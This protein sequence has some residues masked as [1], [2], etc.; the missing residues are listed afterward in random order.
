[1]AT[2]RRKPAASSSGKRKPATPAKKKV[3]VRATKP[4]AVAGSK[5]SFTA[6]MRERDAATKPAVVKGVIDPTSFLAITHDLNVSYKGQQ[7]HVLDV[8]WEERAVAIHMGAELN[9]RT[10]QFIYSGSVLPAVLHKYKSED[11]SLNRWL[12]D[13]IN[14]KYSPNQKPI[15]PLFLPRAHQQEGIDDVRQAAQAGWRGFIEADA[16]GLGKSIVGLLGASEVAKVRGFT[17]QKKAKLLIICPKS[18]IPHWRNTMRQSGVDNLRVLIINYDQYKRLLTVPASADTAKKARTKN[19][20]IASK[21]KSFIKWDIIIA[22]EAHKLKTPTAQRS[23]AFET[24]AEYTQTTAKAPFVLWMSATIGQ[25]PMELSYLAPLIG[26]AAK[27]AS[28]TSSTWG[29]WLF[30]NGFHVKKAKVGYE[31][32]K[33]PPA[34]APAAD[35]QKI[36]DMQIEDVRRLA[37]MIFNPKAPSIRRKPED[38]A[39]WPEVQKI[40]QPVKLGRLGMEN[41]NKAWLEFRKEMNL[42]ASG[43]NPKGGLAAMTRFRQKA[44]LTLVSATVE[45]I[46]ELLDNGIQVAVSVEYKETIDAIRSSLRSHGIE[47]AEFSG[48]AGLNTEQE[49]LRFQKGE[50]RV[51]L[52]SVTEGVSFHA[53]EQLSDGTIATP[54]RRATLIH[55]VR[56]SAMQTVQIIGRTHRDGQLSIAYFMYAEETIGS[57]ILTAMLNKLENMNILSGEEDSEESNL[58]EVWDL[59]KAA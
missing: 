3:V 7:V 5:G 41:Y 52:F 57:I 53:K 43:K 34:N 49:R 30:D 18:V 38:I 50:V 15:P 6:Q 56:W 10:R 46:L 37:D 9:T 36:R 22:D 21:G 25:N 1:M 45:N 51:I 33:L 4:K 47:V 55:D 24:I 19:K 12:E 54:H 35:R 44:S 8:P 23:Q 2:P 20:H 27:V 32:I 59:I 14:K 11:Y 42:V 40:A 31:W 39:G 16:T 26:Q 13:Q 29:Q 48:R 58:A 17:A 28:L